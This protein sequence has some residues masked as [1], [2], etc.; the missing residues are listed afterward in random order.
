MLWDYL[1]VAGGGLLAGVDGQL[2]LRVL[3]ALAGLAEGQPDQAFAAQLAV[4]RR[5]FG[6]SGAFLMTALTSGLSGVTARAGLGSA[7]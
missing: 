3:F 6:Y 4:R 5:R 1:G 7:R 2:D